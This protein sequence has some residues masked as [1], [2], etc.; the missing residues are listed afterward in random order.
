VVDGTNVNRL[1]DFLLQSLRMVQVGQFKVPTIYEILYPFCKREV[2]VLLEQALS[3]RDSFDTFHEHLL[4]RFIPARQLSQLRVERYE[5]VQAHNE[6]LGSYIHSVREAALVLR[7]QETELQVVE[8]ILE[9]LTPNQR[10][11]LVFQGPPNSFKQFEHL[12]VVDHNIAF[13]DNTR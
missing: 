1:C 4:K 11:R 10:A 9:G 7:I 13:A 6:S 2:L 8:R 5:R 3:A 12:V